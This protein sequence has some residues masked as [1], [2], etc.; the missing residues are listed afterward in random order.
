[1]VEGGELGRSVGGK[2]EAKR[3][4][5]GFL[6]KEEVSVEDSEHLEEEEG[7]R[8]KGDGEEREEG[9]DLVEIGQRPQR[10]H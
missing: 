10:L 8:R 4:V 6:E 9:D 3:G 7:R 5:V 2:E 1:M